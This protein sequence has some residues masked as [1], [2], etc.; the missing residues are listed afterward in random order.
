MLYPLIGILLG[1]LLGAVLPFE[2]PMAYSSYLSIA[3]LA[4]L[5]SVFGGVQADLEGNF[6][7]RLFITGFFGN[8]ILAALL[9][10]I[11]D[12]VGV[13]IYYAAIFYFGTSLFSNFAKIRRYYFRPRKNNEKQA[14]T[15]QKVRDDIQESD[16]YTVNT[17][18]RPPEERKK[19][20]K[21]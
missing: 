17:T 8:T 16:R 9:T 20:E 13:P 21:K 11:G 15:P 12:R 10:Y 6:D 1:L 7:Q 14:K 5:N 4:A 19:A 18:S 2:I 3:I